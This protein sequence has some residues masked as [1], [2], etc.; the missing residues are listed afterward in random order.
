GAGDGGDD[1]PAQDCGGTVAK[2]YS[3]AIAFSVHSTFAGRCFPHRPG[4]TCAVDTARNAAVNFSSSIRVTFDMGSPRVCTCV[5]G[6]RHCCGTG[7]PFPE[8]FSI[9]V[10]ARLGPHHRVTAAYGWLAWV[11]SFCCLPIKIRDQLPV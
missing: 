3:S 7:R 9:A 4:R 8:W 10:S 1:P 2:A 11:A 6:A 5:R